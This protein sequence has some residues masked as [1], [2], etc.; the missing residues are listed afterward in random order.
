MSTA[1]ETRS[2]SEQRAVSVC[3]LLP[4]RLLGASVKCAHGQCGS[5]SAH[6]VRGVSCCG[7]VLLI[8]IRRLF[9]CLV[10]PPV[11]HLRTLACPALALFRPSLFVT[12]GFVATVRRGYGPWNYGSSWGSWRN[13]SMRNIAWAYGRA[14]RPCSSPTACSVSR[15]SGQRALCVQ[16]PKPPHGRGTHVG[17][18]VA[19]CNTTSRATKMLGAHLVTTRTGSFRHD[20]FSDGPCW[21]S[22]PTGRG[23]SSLW[24]QTPRDSSAA[25]A[26]GTSS[27]APPAS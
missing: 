7:L 18:L 17:R 11:A 27:P 9:V 10:V 14:A 23:S 26:L 16:L 12:Q 19:F 5:S 13:T 6:F 1:G 4:R 8:S 25:G 15:G 22:T 20:V 3:S 24:Q 21:A 2:E